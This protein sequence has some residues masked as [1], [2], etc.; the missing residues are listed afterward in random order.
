MKLIIDRFYEYKELYTVQFGMDYDVI[1]FKCDFP[2]SI[3]SIDTDDYAEVIKGIDKIITNSPNLV[4]CVTHIKHPLLLKNFKKQNPHWG[5]SIE[6]HKKKL[7]NFFA[8]RLKYR[9]HKVELIEFGRRL[10]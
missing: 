9:Q 4:F 2:K 3:F 6:D 1:I 7:R 10:F 8:V 5:T